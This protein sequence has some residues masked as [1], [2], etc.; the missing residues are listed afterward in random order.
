MSSV[1]SV[2]TIAMH[3]SIFLELHEFATSVTGSSVRGHPLASSMNEKDT[4]PRLQDF[5]AYLRKLV[6]KG[7]QI[8]GVLRLLYSKGKLPEL[9]HNH[10]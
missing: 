2:T 10:P 9:E 5:S 6:P 7:N 1:Y 3:L 4:S 8:I